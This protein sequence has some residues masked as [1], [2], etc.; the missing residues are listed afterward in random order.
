MSTGALAAQAHPV[1]PRLDNPLHHVSVTVGRQGAQVHGFGSGEVRFD[2]DTL[3]VDGRAQALRA[4]PAV[5]SGARIAQYLG[6]GVGAWYLNTPFGIEQGFVLSQPAKQWTGIRMT[7]GGDLLPYHRGAGL[8][9]AGFGH[10]KDVLAYSRL[11]AYDADHRRLPARLMLD[12]RQLTLSVDTRGAHYPV[13]LDPMLGSAPVLLTSLAGVSPEQIASSSDGT[14]LLIGAPLNS[15]EGDVF[16]VTKSGAT[17]NAAVTLANPIHAAAAFGGSV[18]LSADGQTAV[19]GAPGVRQVL[20]YSHGSG[21][22]TL[23]AFLPTSN[24]AFR[25]HLGTA[26]AISADGHTVLVGAPDSSTSFPGAAYVYTGSGSTWNAPVA[27]SI[28]SSALGQS[29]GISSAGAA[30]QLSSDGKRAVVGSP[31]AHTGRGAIYVYDFG[32]SWSGPTALSYPAS[33]TTAVLLGRDIAM[34]GDGSVILAK[35]MVTGQFVDKLYAYTRSPS[36]GS[37]SSPQELRTDALPQTELAGFSNTVALSADGSVALVGSPDGPG[38]AAYVYTRSGTTWSRPAALS[39]SGQGGNI[40]LGFSVALTPDGLKAFVGASG[41]NPVFVYG[42]PVAMDFNVDPS[43]AGKVTPGSQ[44]TLAFTIAD[45]DPD[46]D[47][48]GLLLDEVLPA[49]ASYVSSDGGSGTCSYVSASNSVR[50]KLTSLSHPS[51]TWQPSV[52]LKVPADAG[53]VTNVAA[54]TADQSLDGA[55]ELNTSITVQAASGGSGGGTTTS[56]SGGGAM[57]F[58]SLLALLG[59]ALGRRRLTSI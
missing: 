14:V 23:A 47:V 39:T 38:G 37:W 16:V 34:S 27:L 3:V 29:D 42:S 52:T 5:K 44:V 30:V 11:I 41:D 4:R 26:V 19:V 40:E 10:S 7:L 12:G 28:P 45:T 57:D 2:P 51:G 54:L 49:G 58:L 18:G 56:S 43:P 55:S 33:A 22:W 36:S 17:W 9:F 32:S 24:G 1:P 31:G 20:M 53:T 59:F 21:S 8:G 6:H 50:C 13:T 48:T 15:T 35:S 25:A 46:Q